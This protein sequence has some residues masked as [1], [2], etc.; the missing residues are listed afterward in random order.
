MWSLSESDYS[1]GINSPHFPT[2]QSNHKAVTQP[3]LADLDLDGDAELVIA[4][5]DRNSDNPTVV[6]LTLSSSTPNDFDWEVVLDRGT[7]P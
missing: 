1:I 2:S 6:A 3:L 7:H 4:V 5:V